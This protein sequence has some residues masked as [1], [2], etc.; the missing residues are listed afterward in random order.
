MAHEEYTEVL[1]QKEYSSS[2]NTTTPQ[3]HFE[4]HV[5]VQ[6]DNMIPKWKTTGVK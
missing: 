6:V 5:S 2:L 3:H 4:T 1:A